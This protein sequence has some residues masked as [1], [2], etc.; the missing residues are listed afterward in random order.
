MSASTKTEIADP[1]LPQSV[2]VALGSAAHDI[3]IA[4]QRKEIEDHQVEAIM[5]AHRDAAHG[6]ANDMNLLFNIAVG[7]DKDALLK[8]VESVF[9]VPRSDSPTADEIIQVLAEHYDESLEVVVDW[10]GTME[11]SGMAA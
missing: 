11:F 10:L 2:A 3:N 9:G 4:R 5:Q 8:L 1:T 7:R 6:E